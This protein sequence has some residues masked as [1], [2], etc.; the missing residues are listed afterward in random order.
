MVSDL[1]NFAQNWSKI[2]TAIKSFTD[3]FICSLRLHI[4]FPPLPKVQCPNFLDIWSPWKKVMERSGLRYEPTSQNPMS[5][6]FKICGILWKNPA[7][8]RQSISRPMRIVA[9]IPKNPASKAKF[10]EK[11]TF[12]CEVILHPL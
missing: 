6:L 11:E 9:P 3:F 1:N 7:Y 2:V 4:F 10:A 8:G 12:Y 5:S